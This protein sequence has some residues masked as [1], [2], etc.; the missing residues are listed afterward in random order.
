MIK[1]RKL[2]ALN[3]EDCEEHPR[4]NMARNSNVPKSRDDYITQVSEEFEGR[5]T[6]KLSEEFSETESRRTLNALSRLDDSLTNSLFQG[7]SGTAPQTSR[8]AY[9]TSQ[10]TNEDDSQSDPEPERLS[11]RIRHHENLARMLITA[12]KIILILPNLR[13]KRAQYTK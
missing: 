11:K 10:G 8:N 9:S 5:L 7:H 12:T 6:K 13:H 3:K 1:K 2:A 4:S